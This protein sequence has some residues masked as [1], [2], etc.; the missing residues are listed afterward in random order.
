MSIERLHKNLQRVNKLAQYALRW[1]SYTIVNDKSSKFD[2]VGDANKNI[3]GKEE[4]RRRRR[5]KK[6]TG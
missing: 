6:K 2:H 3:K 1:Q 5:K 4:R